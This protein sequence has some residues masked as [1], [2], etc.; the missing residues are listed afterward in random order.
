MTAALCMSALDDEEDS[1]PTRP[2]LFIMS[3]NDQDDDRATTPTGAAPPPSEP[4]VERPTQPPGE[5]DAE[6]TRV[7][8][9]M[10]PPAP[11]PTLDENGLV[12][13]PSNMPELLYNQLMRAHHEGKQR[14]ADLYDEGGKFAGLLGGIIDRSLTGFA[15]LLEP[16]LVSI[17]RKLAKLEAA[18]A[19]LKTDT[20]RRFADFERLIAELKEERDTPEPTAPTG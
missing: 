12:P 15:Q 14:D 6:A 10:V 3:N 8:Q 7:M 2:N 1:F 17:E 5:D 4:H 9:T 16:R 11:V 20:D 18:H 19:E 13:K